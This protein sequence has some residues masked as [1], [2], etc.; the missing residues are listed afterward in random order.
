MNAAAKLLGDMAR[1]KQRVKKN[2]DKYEIVHA[3]FAYSPS[4]SYGITVTPDIYMLF[5]VNSYL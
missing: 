4:W 5:S 1:I 3:I 2:R